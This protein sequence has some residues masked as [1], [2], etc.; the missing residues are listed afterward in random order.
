MD[1]LTHTLTG[2]IMARAGLA[3]SGKRGETL[4]I[5]LAA[6]TPDVDVLWSG[7]PGS[8]RYFEYHRGISHSLALLPV[9]ALIPLLLARLIGK[10]SISWRLYAACFVGVLSHLAMDLTNV[11]GVRLLL[12]FSSRWLRLDTNDLIDPWIL[13]I[14]VVAIGAPAL[15]GLVG[16]EIAGRKSAPPKHAWAWFAIIAILCYD[17]FRLAAHQRA[18]AVMES[19]LYGSLQ[20]PRYT[21]LP[22]RID[23]LRWR[24]IVETEEFV[25]LTNLLLTEE[26]DPSVFGRIEYPTVKSAAIDAARTTDPFQVLE[27]FSQVPFWKV[28]PAGDDVLVELIDLRFGTPRNPGFATASALVTPD[29][30]VREARAGPLRFR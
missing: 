19:R 23:P 5:M 9:M 2:L 1:N 18:I 14:L 6:N 21:A 22:D 25:V 28:S 12:P 15:A 27:K 20:T 16:S 11:Y 3:R 7:L 17:G 4:A 10:A 29:G 26:Y 8:L 24:A 13:F 30:Q